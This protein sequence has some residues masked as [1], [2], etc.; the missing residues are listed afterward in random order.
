MRRAAPIDPRTHF[1]IAIWWALQL[2][3]GVWR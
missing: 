1:D 2:W 3:F